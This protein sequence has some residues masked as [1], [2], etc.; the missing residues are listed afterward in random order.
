M[1]VM[2]TV[3]VASTYTPASRR[4]RGGEVE[5][6]ASH[7]QC[8]GDG[9]GV[10]GCRGGGDGEGVSRTRG[11]GDIAAE[12]AV[13]G[14]GAGIHTDGR[15][16]EGTGDRERSVRNP[17]RTGV[18]VGVGQDHRA[19]AH[20]GDRG[21][22]GGGSGL[23]G[24]LS[25]RILDHAGEGHLST[26]GGGEGD[27]LAGL[28]GRAEMDGGGEGGVVGRV[29]AEGEDTGARVRGVVRGE[30]DRATDGEG[31]TR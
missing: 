8:A 30:P 14:K 27:A 15:R 11:D 17:G 22:S 21:E 2:S 9:A 19:R 28:A 25:G 18:G 12:V 29:A 4:G 24:V 3:A 20:F 23:R 7:R 26:C 6:A 1:P 5:D 10:L 16:S 31:P 13:A